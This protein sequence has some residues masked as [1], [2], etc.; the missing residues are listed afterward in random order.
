[1]L[2]LEAFDYLNEAQSTSFPCLPFFFL[3]IIQFYTQLNL[4]TSVTEILIISGLHVANQ[5]PVLLLF[6]LGSGS[7]INS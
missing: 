3:L 1:M 5:A 6:G 4:I 2:L 7:S